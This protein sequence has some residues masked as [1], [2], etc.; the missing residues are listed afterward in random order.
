LLAPALL[1]LS[2]V[3]ALLNVFLTLKAILLLLEKNKSPNSKCS[4]IASSALLRVFFT[5]KLCSFVGGGAK[6]FFAPGRK[7]PWLRHWAE[8]RKAPALGDF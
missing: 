3:T 7:V 4:A 6:I 5:F 2:T 1:L 8:E